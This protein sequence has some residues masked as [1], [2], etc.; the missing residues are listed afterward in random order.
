[1]E[2]RRHFVLPGREIAKDLRRTLTTTRC[3]M[4][5]KTI[6]ADAIIVLNCG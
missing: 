3:G 6:I 1:M 2:G 5:R 4:A